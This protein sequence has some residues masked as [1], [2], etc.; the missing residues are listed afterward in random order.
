[1]SDTTAEETN[2]RKSLK[3]LA[4]LIPFILPYKG[5]LALALIALLIASATVLALP[6]AV[7]EVIDHGFSTNDATQI[8]R[9][10]LAL[11]LFA[12]LIGFFGAAR[13]YFVNWLG[14]RVVADLRDRIFRHVVAMD[15][16]FFETNKIGEVLSRLTA[17]TT[18]IQSISGA[19]LSIV[20]RSSIQFVGALALMAYTNLKLTAFLVVLLPLVITPI[21]MIGQWVRRLSRS[22]QDR[23]ADASGYAAEILNAVETVQVFTAEKRES[24]RFGDAIE[25]SFDTAVLRIRV[26]ALMTMAATS[27]LFGAFIFVLWMGAKE[28]LAASISG[29]E[30]GQFVIYAVLVGASGA[31]LSEFWG[32]LQRAAGAMERIT[33]LLLMRP[34]IQT[35]L[36]PLLIPPANTRQVQFDSVNFSYPSRPDKPAISQF[37][38]QINPGEHIALVGASGA[39]KSTVFQLLLRFYDPASGRILIDGVDIAKVDPAEVRSLIGIVPQETTIFGL[40]AA[41]NIRF[42]RPNASDAEI[43][44]AAQAAHADGFIKL[45]HDGYDTYLGEKGARLSGGQKQRIAIARA[46]LKDPPILLLDEATSSLDAD[47]ERLVQFALEKLQQNRTTMVIAHRLST[48]LKADHI[49]LME[50]GKIRNIGTHQELMNREPHYVRMVELQF[51]SSVLN[52]TGFSV[53]TGENLSPGPLANDP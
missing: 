28:V 20:L 13:A 33:E 23:I 48:V 16:T 3:P 26:R 27:M 43:V 40:S 31:A 42:G 47:S 2:K 52:Q 7:R 30:L 11:M 6:V 1:M 29:G 14:E 9:Y 36:Q 8:D 22:S 18:L 37:S 38:L 51:D 10:F 17:D 4:M 25:S 50:D 53:P 35:P 44:D 41:E 5:T 49:V 12:L 32:E 24:Q 15:P 19:G 34:A 45:L 46:V 39:G 21:L